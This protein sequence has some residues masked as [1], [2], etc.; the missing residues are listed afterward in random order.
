M[1][2]PERPKCGWDIWIKV[3]LLMH[4]F[5][6]LFDCS[7]QGYEV[8]GHVHVC[9]KRHNTLWHLSSYPV[10]LWRRRRGLHCPG[11]W[12]P[13]VPLRADGSHQPYLPASISAAT[14]H[15]QAPGYRVSAGAEC[16]TVHGLCQGPSLWV[17]QTEGFWEGILGSWPFSKAGYWGRTPCRKVKCDV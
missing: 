16:S 10:H 4:K 1:E 13:V 2:I 17:H 7:N 15:C 14:V 5:Y 6:F 8:L 11:G 3:F 12:T 9:A